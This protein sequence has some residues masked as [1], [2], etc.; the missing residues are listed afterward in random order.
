MRDFYRQKP[1]CSAIDCAIETD[2]V[3]L[4]RI[5]G[6]EINLARLNYHKRRLPSLSP[7]GC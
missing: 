3:D 1:L 5:K 2:R 7:T 6:P 4:R